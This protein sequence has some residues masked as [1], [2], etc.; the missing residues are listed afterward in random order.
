MT[1][2]SLLSVPLL[3]HTTTSKCSEI[4]SERDL[5]V[6]RKGQPELKMM[7][8]LLNSGW[9][10]TGS[11]SWVQRFRV[12]INLLFLKDFICLTLGGGGLILIVYLI[13]FRITRTNLGA[14]PWGIFC[15][16]LVNVH[17]EG[18]IYPECGRYQ[19]LGQG[20]RLNAKEKFIWA[21][22]CT[23]LCFLTTLA[24]WPAASSSCHHPF[25]MMHQTVC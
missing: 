18:E 9:S 19:I 20:L 12:R 6:T 23:P 14:G 11:L 3:H 7:A 10:R 21:P 8:F 4:E 15:R 2:L 24:M 13:W 16:V 22:A 25:L 17:W 1:L 5:D